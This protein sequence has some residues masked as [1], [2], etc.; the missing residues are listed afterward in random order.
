MRKTQSVYLT[1]FAT[2]TCTNTS[3]RTKQQVSKHLDSSS[4]KDVVLK[5][6]RISLGLIKRVRAPLTSLIYLRNCRSLVPSSFLYYICQ[7][8]PYSCPS[9][10][11]CP[12][13]LLTSPS[14]PAMIFKANNKRNQQTRK[15]KSTTT[16]ARSWG[17]WRRRRW[18]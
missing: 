2:T 5:K 9:K 18:L 13:H 12:I 3:Q 1:G 8:R 16:R 17:R 6:N 4:C 11:S 15:I 14:L 10:W 7:F